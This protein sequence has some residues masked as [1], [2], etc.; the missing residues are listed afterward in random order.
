MKS[1]DLKILCLILSLL[2]S[3]AIANE[4][5]PR[6]IRNNNPGN[7]RPDVWTGWPNAINADEDGYIVFKRPIDG[8]RAIVINLNIYK[9]KH[10]INTVSGIINRWTNDISPERRVSY[11]KFVSDN[12]G[13]YPDA[14]LNLDDALTLKKLTK[15]IIFYENG[16]DPYS[17]KIYS[18]IFPYARD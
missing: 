14:I 18:S 10:G 3:N 13:V 8:V 12:L 2:V 6:G 5:E 11:I 15:S 17:E 7:L 9:K 4:L 1:A 16:I